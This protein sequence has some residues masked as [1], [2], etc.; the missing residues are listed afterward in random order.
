MPNGT[1]DYYTGAPVALRSQDLYLPSAVAAY[2]AKPRGPGPMRFDPGAMA[3]RWKYIIIAAA[4][5][6]L[7]LTAALVTPVSYGPSGTVINTEGRLIAVASNADQGVG[8]STE[9]TL[10]IGADRYAGT[11]VAEELVEEGQVPVLITMVELN[12]RVPGEEVIGSFAMVEAGKRSLLVDI[13]R[14]G[15]L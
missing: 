12:D 2:R 10:R 14:K 4:V 3:P 1:G 7:V 15:R 6:T 13:L 8:W 11:V 9:V 5:L